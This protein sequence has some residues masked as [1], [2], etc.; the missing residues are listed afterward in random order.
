M[1]T[2]E[3]IRQYLKNL[4]NNILERLKEGHSQVRLIDSGKIELLNWIL[5]D[6]LKGG[7]KDGK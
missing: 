2:E 1:R 7:E 4:E 3:E 6:D 5:N